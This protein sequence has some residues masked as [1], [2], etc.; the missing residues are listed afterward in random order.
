MV[1]DRATFIFD[2][3]EIKN[4]A[5]GGK[6]GNGGY[7][8]HI[9]KITNVYR[10]GDKIKAGATIQ[11]ITKGGIVIKEHYDV[12]DRIRNSGI[13]FCVPSSVSCPDTVANSV[14]VEPIEAVY[15]IPNYYYVSDSSSNL[16]APGKRYFVGF[17]AFGK[18][19]KNKQE[20]LEFM[21]KYQ[22]ITIP[23]GAEKE[24][25]LSRKD[26]VRLAQLKVIFEGEAKYWQQQQ[27]NSPA[28][29][30]KQK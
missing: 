15:T 13:F 4:Y 26:S 20:F 18:N 2:G 3:N 30:T 14:C 24:E 11:I 17:E 6:G 9:F 7:I 5:F 27:P 19:F 29:T 16:G 23:I 1:F 8:S 10:G 22:N 28:D 12:E 21:K 25:P